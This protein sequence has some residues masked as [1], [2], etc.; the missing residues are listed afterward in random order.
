MFVTSFLNDIVSG[1][2]ICS[3]FQVALLGDWLRK[4]F[5]VSLFYVFVS[6]IS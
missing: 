3:T 5:V 2:C 6:S 1:S 4:L